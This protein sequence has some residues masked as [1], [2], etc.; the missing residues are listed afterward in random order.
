MYKLTDLYFL[1]HKYKIN[2]LMHALQLFD[3]IPINVFKLPL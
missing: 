1:E 3:L 2:F